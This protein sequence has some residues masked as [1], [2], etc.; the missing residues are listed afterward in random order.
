MVLSAP[1][2]ASEALAYADAVWE[3]LLGDLALLV[4][5]P[6]VVDMDDVRPGAPWGRACRE[7]LD[8]ALF[9]AERLGL[10][11]RDGGGHL[12]YA[13]LAGTS[14]SH[15]AGIAHVDVV[16]A[17]G[18][19]LTDPFSL[20]RRGGM[21]VGRGVLDD[22]GAAIAMLYAAAFFVGRGLPGSV[23][24]RCLLGASEEAGMQDVRWYRAHHEQPLFC[25]TP[26]ASFPVCCGEKGGVNAELSWPLEKDGRIVSISGGTARNAVPDVAEAVVRVR[27]SE[28]PPSPGVVVESAG[29]CLARVR[30]VGTGG[31]AAMPEGTV[32]AVGV[33]VNYLIGAVDFVARERDYLALEYD[34]LGVTDGSGVGIAATDDLFDPLTCVG[35]TIRTQGDRVVQDIDIRFPRSTSVERIQRG[36]DASASSRGC[37]LNVVHAREPYFVDPS[38]PE[39]RALL[40][41]YAEVSG[42]PSRPFTIGGGTYAH[43]FDRAVAFG[44]LDPSDELPAWA[45]PEH[46]ANEAIPEA[47]L[48][49]ALATYVVAFDRLLRLGA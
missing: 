17:G 6:S 39:V 1:V 31:H 20:I 14:P 33:L 25:F 47:S 24:I 38:S 44:P 49:R 19:W 16:P 11:V 26:D 48:K 13:E 2:G 7:A 9:V 5:V 36:L 22:K 35:T 18:G 40:D 21:L 12:G 34:I 43:H 45:G 27:S 23:G 4:A 29:E 3:D 28:L 15:V 42:R 30:A 32:N 41:A 46:G 37:S 10:E 8:R